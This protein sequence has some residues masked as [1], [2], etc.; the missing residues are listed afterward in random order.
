MFSSP[1][2]NVLF[3]NALPSWMSRATLLVSLKLFSPSSCGNDNNYFAEF[4]A[5]YEMTFESS[6]SSEVG[7]NESSTIF[8]IIADRIQYA[9][10]FQRVL[11]KQSKTKC[12][13]DSFEQHRS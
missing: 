3:L 6:L 5:F 7:K 13:F 12:I 4:W 11:T 9:K 1:V 10:K 2:F 8:I